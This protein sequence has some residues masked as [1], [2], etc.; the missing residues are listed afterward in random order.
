MY[1]DNDKLWIKFDYKIKII[2]D[3]K[4]LGTVVEV[5]TLKNSLTTFLRKNMVKRGE[6]N[7]T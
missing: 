7:E 4:I 1:S 3:Y 5:K 2:I 6:K